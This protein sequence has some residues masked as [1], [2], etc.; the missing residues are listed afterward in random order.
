MA[1]NPENINQ[2]KTWPECGRLKNTSSE[3]STDNKNIR[4]LWL[5][6]NI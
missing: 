1:M 2:F 5:K 3:F 4:F 6:A